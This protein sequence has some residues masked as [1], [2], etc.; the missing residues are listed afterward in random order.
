MISLSYKSN[1][2]PHIT[3]DNHGTRNLAEIFTTIR[4]PHQSNESI[5]LT[6]LDFLEQA[7]MMEQ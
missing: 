7:G 3:G 4:Y 5:S 2:R 1:T 6:L